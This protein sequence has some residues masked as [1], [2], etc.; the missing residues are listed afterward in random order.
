MERYG[1]RE[2]DIPSASSLP[3]SNGLNDQKLDQAESRNSKNFAGLH[4][5]VRTKALGLPVAHCFPRFINRELDGN[6]SH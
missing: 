4:S 5:G 1:E 3:R 6:C 2:R